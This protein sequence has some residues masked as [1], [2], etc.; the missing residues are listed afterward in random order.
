M[1]PHSA[2]I[3]KGFYATDREN[4]KLYSTAWG[5]EEPIVI[6]ILPYK[7]KMLDL[8]RKTNLKVNGVF[9]T[10]LFSDY[11]KFCQDRFNSKFQEY[12][13]NQD[14][15]FINSHS[16]EDDSVGEERVKRVQK[17]YS[18]EYFRQYLWNL[19]KLGKN[20]KPIEL[21]RML[22]LMDTG[23]ASEYAGGMFA[24]F[25]MQQGYDGLIY[26][27][28]GDHP[29]QKQPLSYVF[30]DPEVIGTYETWHPEEVNLTP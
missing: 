9:P 16:L 2:T 28:G 25:M 7:A 29:D 11:L 3:G 20:Q 23:H 13:P 24:Q 8:R 5:Q 17:V 4:A 18:Y 14:V 15:E 19:E 26:F 21:R 1:E 22:S 12:N 27:E 30:Y 6:T 10:N